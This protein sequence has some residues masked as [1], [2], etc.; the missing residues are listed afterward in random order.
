MY[1]LSMYVTK[2]QLCFFSNMKSA[3][4]EPAAQKTRNTLITL[5]KYGSTLNKPTWNELTIKR[6]KQIQISRSYNETIWTIQNETRQV[7]FK[8]TTFCRNRCKF[9]HRAHIS[10]GNTKLCRV[11][12]P[13]LML[14]G[15]NCLLITIQIIVYKETLSYKKHVTYSELFIL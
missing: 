15:G 7:K 2:F 12:I 9:T 3:N 1:V 8:W 14:C 11:S 10:E 6:V 4:I 13:P 5:T